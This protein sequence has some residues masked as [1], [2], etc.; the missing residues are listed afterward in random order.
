MG[1]TPDRRPGPLI[2]EE[3]IQ[4]GTNAG[5]P[6]VVGGI[7]YNGSSFQFK[8]GTGTFDPRST[9]GGGTT[10]IYLGTG[11]DYTTLAS[12]MSEATTRAGAGGWAEIIVIGS[13]T[14]TSQVDFGADGITIRGADQNAELVWNGTFDLLDLNAHHDIV[15]RDLHFRSTATSQQNYSAIWDDTITALSSFKCLDCEFDGNGYQGEALYLNYVSHAEIR[16]NKFVDFSIG[17]NAIVIRVNYSTDLEISGNEFTGGAIPIYLRPSSL[18][19]NVRDNSMVDL[20]SGSS[21]Y[22]VYIEGTTQSKSG[23]IVGNSIAWTG[24]TSGNGLYITGNT[25]SDWLRITDNTIYGIS[26]GVI[27]IYV[28]T[29]TTLDAIVANNIVIGNSASYGSYGIFLEPTGGSFSCGGNRVDHFQQGIWC[30][31]GSS[32]VDHN[33]VT[34]CSSYGIVVTGGTEYNVVSSNNVDGTSHSI[35]INGSDY[36]NVT[37]NICKTGIKSTSGSDRGIFT[38]NICASTMQIDSDYNNLSGNSFSAG[39]ILIYGDY[40]LT[41]GNRYIGGSYTDNGTG[42]NQYDDM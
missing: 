38:N 8:D 11:Q 39:G 18:R 41:H 34:D 31:T 23:A 42:N 15:V 1:Q 21:S 7:R 12:A 17:T 13:V 40:N 19:W 32:T 6:S 35:Y 4:L 14:T 2:E 37:G 22:G 28:G 16:Q 9:G 5:D 10:P 20:K 30:S 29:T 27:G 33:T 3:E 24:S 26:S 36:C 25:S